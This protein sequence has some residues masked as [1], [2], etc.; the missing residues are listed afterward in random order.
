M[1]SAE[2]PRLNGILETA[3][4]VDDIARSAPF[5]QSLFGF[6]PVYSGPRL[7]ALAVR[8]G[9]VLLLFQKK[10]SSN[11]PKIPHEGDGRLHLAFAISREELERWEGRL[12]AMGI[13]I[14]EK[15]SWERGGQSLYF[16]DPDQHLIELATPGLWA[17]Y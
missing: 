2:A 13:P 7:T 9:Q 12:A 8:E 17:N 3:L 6:T 16:R 14:V 11:L 5:Y 4:Y 15:T 10:A 1:S